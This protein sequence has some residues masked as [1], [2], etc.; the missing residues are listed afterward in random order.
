MSEAY[1]VMGQA[2]G[3][4]SAATGALRLLGLNCWGTDLSSDDRE[5]LETCRNGPSIAPIVSQRNE[6]GPWVTKHPDLWPWRD[7]LEQVIPRLRWI[8]VFRDPVAVAMHRNGYRAISQHRLN[9]IAHLY[10]EFT[11]YRTRRPALYL[12]YEK[13]C[14]APAEGIKEMARFVCMPVNQKAIDFID[15]AKGYQNIKEALG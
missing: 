9:V 3:G 4:T 8:F 10:G 15:P 7:V 5:L 13:L 12:S 11:S 2:K 6:S 1:I 14:A